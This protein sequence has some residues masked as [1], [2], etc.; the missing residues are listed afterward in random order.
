M[1]VDFSQRNLWDGVLNGKDEPSG[2]DF[3]FLG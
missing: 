2:R 3:S 1:A